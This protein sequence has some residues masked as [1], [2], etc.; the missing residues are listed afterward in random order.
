[1][2]VALTAYDL[3]IHDLCCIV[4]C[5]LTLSPSARVAAVALPRY[6]AKPSGLAQ[7]YPQRQAIPVLRHYANASP[8]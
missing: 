5:S 3:S 6:Y 1:M 2:V 8:Y 4:W 7:G